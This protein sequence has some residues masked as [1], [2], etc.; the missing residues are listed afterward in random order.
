MA[1]S[2]DTATQQV[3]VYTFKFPDSNVESVSGIC[4]VSG[5]AERNLQVSEADT[6]RK[7]T[8]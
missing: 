5:T 3:Q 4:S 2:L 6:G 7:S 1:L 8:Q